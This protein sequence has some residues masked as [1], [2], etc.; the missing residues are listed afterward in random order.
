MDG[1]QPICFVCLAIRRL[2]SEKTRRPAGRSGVFFARG[3]TQACWRKSRTI[4]PQ[5]AGRDVLRACVPLLTDAILSIT[6][7]GPERHILEEIFCRKSRSNPQAF[8]H[9]ERAP[10]VGTVEAPGILFLTGRPCSA[11][12][13]PC[14]SFPRSCPGRRNGP[15]RRCRRRWAVSGPGCG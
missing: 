2:S 1:R 12:A 8:G 3:R 4:T 15:G 7:V 5:R 14:R 13:P 11:G 10:A 9:R 6:Q